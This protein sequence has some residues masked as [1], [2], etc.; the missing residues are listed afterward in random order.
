MDPKQARAWVMYDWANSAFATTMIAAVLP[1]FYQNV[2][3]EGLDDAIATSYWAF[4]Q[5]IAMILVAVLSPIL[6]A[7]A[8]VG[9]RKGTYLMIAAIVGAAASSAMALTGTGDYIFVSILFIIAT[10]GFSGGNTFYDSMLRDI[11]PPPERDMLSARG[12]MFGYIGGGLLLLVHVIMIQGW[13]SIGFTSQIQAMQLVFL[14]SGLWWLLF[15][16]PLLRRFPLR[17][18]GAS[19]SA[20]RSVGQTAL[21]SVKSVANTLLHVKK[22]P[23]L[24]K[25]LIAFWF[26][27]DG[28]STI[29]SMAAIYGAEIGIGTTHL[30]TALLITQFVGVPFTFLFGKLAG[31]I[32]AKR[33]LYLSL[34]FYVVI[35]IFGFFMESALHFYILAFMVG[36]VQ[37][38]S[39]SLARSIYSRLVPAHKTSEFFGF[40]SLSGKVSAALGPAVFGFTAAA[41]GT[42]RLA[43]LSVL[44]FFVAGIWML[45]RVNLAKGEAEASEDSEPPITRNPGKPPAAT[46]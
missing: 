27:N 31:K 28:I 13:E 46:L 17:D 43:I 20:S 26:F 2:A 14:T 6:G 16:I 11:A 30:I 9:G 38:G 3:A 1:I 7:A 24:F 45:T 39:Q 22:Y 8:D 35:V 12:Y 25:Y 5:T 29:I 37:G 34:W 23:E 36:M 4:S 19:R 44:I 33:S 21:H 41:T 18:K 15:A 42:S 32:G 40:M 10:L